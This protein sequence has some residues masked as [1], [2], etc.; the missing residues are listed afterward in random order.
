MYKYVYVN[1]YV[2]MKNHIT[3]TSIEMNNSPFRINS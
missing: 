2:Y 3:N 1:M